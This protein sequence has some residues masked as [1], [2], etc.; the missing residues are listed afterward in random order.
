MFRGW[1]RGERL[2]LEVRD[3]Q[4]RVGVGAGQEHVG[5]L[6]SPLVEHAVAFFCDYLGRYLHECQCGD[7]AGCRLPT[8]DRVHQ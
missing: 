4:Q 3:S 5:G 1:V 6:C 2:K 7:T 8:L